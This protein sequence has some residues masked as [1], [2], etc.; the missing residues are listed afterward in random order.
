MQSSEPDGA[1]HRHCAGDIEQT[2]MRH[3]RAVR[4]IIDVFRFY[5][6]LLQYF[7]L[8]LRK[9]QLYIQYY[10]LKAAGALLIE[11]VKI[12]YCI[13]SLSKE[14]RVIFTACIAVSIYIVALVM[15][16]RM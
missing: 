15:F 12:E 7:Y 9:L 8:H 4:T 13:K 11:A 16:I 14:E 10:L 2:D 1:K 3:K 5:G 6:L